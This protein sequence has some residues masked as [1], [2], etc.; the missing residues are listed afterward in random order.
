[1]SCWIGAKRKILIH[2][3]H[4]HTTLLISL[5]ALWSCRILSCNHGRSPY[6]E[7][8]SRFLHVIDELNRRIT[9]QLRDPVKKN[10]SQAEKGGGPR[11]D[12]SKECL[13]GYIWWGGLIE[14]LLGGV[15][16]S[17]NSRLG[18]TSNTERRGGWVGR[19]SLHG[20]AF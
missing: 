7:L 1:M 19:N 16:K 5:Y 3:P 10:F 20:L 8:T 14:I 12:G 9:E 2:I 13:S 11:I 15:F 6:G 17:C 4:P 18:G